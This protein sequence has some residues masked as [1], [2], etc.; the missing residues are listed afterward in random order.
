M[1]IDQVSSSRRV[2]S[3]RRVS[4]IMQPKMARPPFPISVS[5]VFVRHLLEHAMSR[6]FRVHSGDLWGCRRGRAP[7]AFARQVGM[8]LA[9]VA[10]GLSLTEVGLVFARDR[11]TVAY[12]CE[13]V[14]RLRDD[15]D[16][17]R[18]LDLLESVLRFLAPSTRHCA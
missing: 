11:T 5:E 18:S 7:A 14:E 12:A 1:N 8:Y 15:V 2:K 4:L 9:H 17:D 16:F 10:F 13:L 6:A 3:R